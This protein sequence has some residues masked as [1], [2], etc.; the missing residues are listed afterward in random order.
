MFFPSDL[1]NTSLETFNKDKEAR[2]QYVTKL[3]DSKEATSQSIQ[4]NE[5]KKFSA[6]I[7]APHRKGRKSIKILIHYNVPENYPK[8]KW[9]FL[10]FFYWKLIKFVKDIV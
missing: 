7:Q 2:K 6:F 1:R 9:V 4:P 8:I 10:E 5:T 3:L